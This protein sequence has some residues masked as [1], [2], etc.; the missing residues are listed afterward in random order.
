MCHEAARSFCFPS[1]QVTAAFSAWPWTMCMLRR[2]SGAAQGQQ[3]GGSFQ[4]STMA[5]N[6]GLFG[7]CYLI[8][9]SKSPFW[10]TQCCC[11]SS[12]HRVQPHFSHF[13][14]PC[15]MVEV[16]SVLCLFIWC[17][18]EAF[19]LKLYACQTACGGMC[20]GIWSLRG[21]CV[22]QN[23][24]EIMLMVWEDHS[25]VIKIDAALWRLEELA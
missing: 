16:F 19:K 4:I 20:A 8:C 11:F 23:L 17:F 13:F 21:D 12:E 25:C 10:K 7:V 2:G 3:Q 18:S 15:S 22:D 24:L 9:F 5:V 14:P 1:E 6:A